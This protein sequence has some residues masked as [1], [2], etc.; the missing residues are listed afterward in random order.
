MAAKQMKEIGRP[1]TGPGGIRIGFTVEDALR[2]CAHG[3]LKLV[4]GRVLTD[5]DRAEMIDRILSYE[6]SK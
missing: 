5:E 6:I 3:N 2:L 1:A 4:E